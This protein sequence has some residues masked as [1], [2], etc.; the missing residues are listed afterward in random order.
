MCCA[1]HVASITVFCFVPQL[2]LPVEETSDHSRHFCGL[3]NSVLTRFHSG[4]VLCARKRI[5]ILCKERYRADYCESIQVKMC[6]CVSSCG[7]LTDE[8]LNR[9]SV[10]DIPAVYCSGFRSGSPLSCLFG[11]QV[12]N[13]TRNS[14]S[15]SLSQ[16]RVSPRSDHPV[17][18]LQSQ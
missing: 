9:P 8:P 10:S 2:L 12:S 11:L 3:K 15:L 18:T 13:E 5:T 4:F 17:I 1:S 14:L 16:T 7:V 6:V